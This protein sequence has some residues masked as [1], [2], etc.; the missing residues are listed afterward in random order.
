MEK[1]VNTI[2]RYLEEIKEEKVSSGGSIFRTMMGFMEMSDGL[3]LDEAADALQVELLLTL[4][5]FRDPLDPLR[6]SL[7]DILLNRS[8]RIRV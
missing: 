8:I 1:H 4:R 7:K 5:K 2:L 6:I 3:N